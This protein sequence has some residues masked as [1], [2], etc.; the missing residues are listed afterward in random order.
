MSSWVGQGRYIWGDAWIEFLFE[1][2]RIIKKNGRVINF[3]TRTYNCCWQL[4]ICVLKHTSSYDL[5]IHLWQ[6]PVFMCPRFNVQHVW[7]HGKLYRLICRDASMKRCS[8]LEATGR[9]V[10]RHVQKLFLW[11]LITLQTLSFNLTI[12]TIQNNV[13]YMLRG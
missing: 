10:S 6:S 1:S 11:A 7:I 2:N 12:N 4:V 3:K 13:I 9:V 8:S 5:V